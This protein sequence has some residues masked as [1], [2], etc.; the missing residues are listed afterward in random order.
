MVRPF[1]IAVIAIPISIVTSRVLNHFFGVK[2][3]VPERVEV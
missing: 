3:K 1:L 2:R